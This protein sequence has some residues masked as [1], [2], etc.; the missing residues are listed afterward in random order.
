[1][2]N[3]YSLVTVNDSN[4]LSCIINSVLYFY[5]YKYIRYNITNYYM[6]RLTA[7]IAGAR[8][9]G[10]RWYLA[11][12]C[13]IEAPGNPPPAMPGADPRVGYRWGNTWG[14]APWAG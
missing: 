10:A 6:V 4:T 8:F 9:L 1:M 2:G 13:Q 3:K 12:N 11:G 5:N 7:H 14:G